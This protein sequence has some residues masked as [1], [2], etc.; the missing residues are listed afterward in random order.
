[1][2]LYIIPQFDCSRKKEDI[3]IHSVENSVDVGCENSQMRDAC[4]DWNLSTEQVELFFSLSERIT[5][6]E[7]HDSYS[8]FPCEIKGSLSLNDTVFEY[9]INGG[10]YAE[11]YHNDQLLYLFGCSN[12][13]CSSFVLIEKTGIVTD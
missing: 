6:R 8:Y 1:M 2:L 13:T 4:S 11:L 10:A 5:S 7:K 9:I 12:D 3:V